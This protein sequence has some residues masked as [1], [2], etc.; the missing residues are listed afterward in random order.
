MN[1]VET[2]RLLNAS[3]VGLYPTE[4][5]DKLISPDLVWIALRGRKLDEQEVLKP[6]GNRGGMETLQDKKWRVYRNA[7]VITFTN[8]DPR[9]TIVWH[10]TQDG[11]KV[12]SFHTCPAQQ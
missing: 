4:C 11:W 9:R 3:E 1:D 7:A 12:V 10:K 6:W 2:R 5:A 8:G